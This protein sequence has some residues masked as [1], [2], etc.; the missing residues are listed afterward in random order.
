MPERGEQRRGGGLVKGLCLAESVVHGGPSA[1]LSALLVRHWTG[2]HTTE[3]R[4]A[5]QRARTTAAQ[6]GGACAGS[7]G[8]GRCLRRSL[9]RL[10]GGLLRCRRS[11][12]R[13]QRPAVAA[14]ASAAGAKR[15]ISVTWRASGGGGQA[16]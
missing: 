7:V 3:S 6:D 14:Q 9:R 10:S 5:T 15:N 16:K 2:A 4:V 12:L 13:C 11:L 8:P 1:N